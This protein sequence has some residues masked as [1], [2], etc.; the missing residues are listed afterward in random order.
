MSKPRPG[1]P[2][3]DPKDPSTPVLVRLPSKRYDEAYAEAAA[4]RV[5]VPELIRQALDSKFRYQK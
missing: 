2:P 5:S 3:L 4:K 1:R